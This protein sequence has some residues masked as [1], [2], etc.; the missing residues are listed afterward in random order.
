VDRELY[1]CQAAYIFE[2]TIAIGAVACV[3][4]C[5]KKALATGADEV[6]SCA[7]PV[8]HSLLLLGFASKQKSSTLRTREILRTAVSKLINAYISGTRFAVFRNPGFSVQAQRACADRRRGP[9]LLSLRFR[10]PQ[11]PLHVL[12]S[13]EKAQL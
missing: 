4:L 11:K 13:P 8:L 5:C 9:L 3:L 7:A 10:K 6:A 12:R 2:A 1:I